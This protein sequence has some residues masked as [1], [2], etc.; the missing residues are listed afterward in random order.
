MDIESMRNESQQGAS[1]KVTI[2]LLKPL[3]K[4][5]LWDV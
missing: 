5:T 2:A 3:G 1:T 4:A